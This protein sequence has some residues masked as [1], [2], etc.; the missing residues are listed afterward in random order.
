VG[1]GFRCNNQRLGRTAQ[2]FRWAKNAVSGLARSLF[3]ILFH[4]S[5]AFPISNFLN[6][7]PC[8]ELLISKHNSNMNNTPTVCHNIIYYYFIIIII[9]YSS[10]YCLIMEERNDFIKISFLIFCFIFSFII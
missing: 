10:S 4:F 6:S 7:N 2:K 3:F 9:I 1:L 5:F 8:F